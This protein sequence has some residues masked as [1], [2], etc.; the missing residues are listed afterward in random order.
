MRI[1]LTLLAGAVAAGALIAAPAAMAAPTKLEYK[2]TV[3]N[4][5]KSD[6]TGIVWATGD[7]RAN[8][9]R[10][11]RRASRGLAV[12]AEDGVNDRLISEFRRK[13]GSRAANVGPRVRAGRSSTFRVRTTTRHRR[14]SLASMAVCSND[15]FLGANKIVLPLKK[16]KKN[17]RVI[18]VRALDAGSERNTETAAHVPCL[19][20][21]FVGQAERGKVRRSRGIRG[22]GDL[23]Q[24]EHGWGKFIGVV[25]ITRVR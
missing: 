2:V 17:R 16:G 25:V 21:H 11:G 23:T 13:K 10:V 9:F 7:R 14:L 18:R 3:S 5:A 15:T 20:A 19:G 12:L 24:A 1:S 22:N 4:K 8:L 6:L